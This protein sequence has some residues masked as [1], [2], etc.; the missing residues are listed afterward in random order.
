VSDHDVGGETVS[1]VGAEA[2]DPEGR[3]RP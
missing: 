2:S 1:V 3:R